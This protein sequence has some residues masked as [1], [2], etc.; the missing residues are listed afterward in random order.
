MNI[1]KAGTKQKK[2]DRTNNSQKENMETKTE[3]RNANTNQG[4][5]AKKK[6]LSWQIEDNFCS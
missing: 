3:G 1:E 4:Q 6:S 5:R 2:D